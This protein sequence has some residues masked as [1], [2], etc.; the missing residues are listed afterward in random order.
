MSETISSNSIV[1]NRLYVYFPKHTNLKRQVF[2]IDEPVES[3]GDF[4]RTIKE[5]F[6]DSNRLFVSIIGGKK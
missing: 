1:L 4:L 6:K 5:D 2:Q 3:V